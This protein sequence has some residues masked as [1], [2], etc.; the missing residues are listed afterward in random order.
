[1]YEVLNLIK[2]YHERQVLNIQHLTIE[3]GEVF[4]IF[5]PNGAG[6]STLLRILHLLEPPDGGEIFCLDRQV[7]FPVPLEFRRRIVMVFQRPVLFRRS[8][9]D[10]VA[11][12]LRL[13]GDVKEERVDAIIQRLDLHSISDVKAGDLSGGEVQR[14]ALA[15]A[16]VL[17]PDV[18]LLDEPTANLDPYNA[19]LIEAIIREVRGEG[20][21]TVVLVSHN[22]HQTVRLADRAGMLFSG[23]LIEVLDAGRMLDEI[24]DPRTRAF[25]DGAMS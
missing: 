23:E 4:A 12:G 8:V 24:T 14:V 22:V 9:R 5:G 6:K 11:Y 17:Q 20:K 16:L 25:V 18:L 1:M 3:P 19:S 15:R 2:S 13:R 21:T 10:N 7:N